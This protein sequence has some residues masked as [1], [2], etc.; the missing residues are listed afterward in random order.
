MSDVISK[1]GVTR[2]KGLLYYIGKDGN[3]W[4]CTRGKDSNTKVFDAKITREP[5]YLYFLNKEGNVARAKMMR[6]TKKK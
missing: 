3:V 6:R 2:Q 4:S 5:G 1:C